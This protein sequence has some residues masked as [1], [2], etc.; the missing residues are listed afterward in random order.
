MSNETVSPFSTIPAEPLDNPAGKYPYLV[1]RIM[2][3]VYQRESIEIREGEPSVHIGYRS[4]YVQYPTPVTTDG[5]ISA[6]CR[7]LLLNGV[8]EAVRRTGFRMSVVWQ[9]GLCSYVERDGT[10]NESEQTP[11]GGIALPAGIVFDQRVPLSTL[12]STPL[13]PKL[14]TNAETNNG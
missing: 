13:K 5:L 12:V 10:I 11:S 2:S 8:L 14:H 7:T 9:P 4:S 1:V 3:S 6:D